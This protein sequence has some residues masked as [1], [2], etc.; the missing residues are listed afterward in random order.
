M[1]MSGREGENKTE[2]I[3]TERQGKV[4]LMTSG[5]TGAPKLVKHTLNALLGRILPSAS[6]AS[7]RE[8]RWL[9]T[10]QPTSFAGMQ[11]ILTAC[12]TG[13]MIVQPL[14]RTA[15]AFYEAAKVHRVTHISGTPTFWRSF[16]L[17]GRPALLSELRQITIGGEAIDQTI[18]NRL[19]TAFPQARLSHIYASTE[20]GALFAVHDRRHGFPAQWLEEGIQGVKLRIREDQLEVLSPHRMVGYAGQRGL[21]TTPDGWLMTGD[22]VRVE[23]DRIVFMG[24]NDAMINVGGTKIFPHEI[25]A[26]LLAMPEIAEAR[27]IG[28]PNP[29]S[30]QIPVA[31]IVVVAGAEGEKVRQAVMKR[32]RESL[33]PERAPRVIRLVSS[34]PVHLS[35]KKG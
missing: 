25:E 17:V 3:E 31:E 18:L 24:R 21:P 6:L 20:A 8:G 30:G 29:I 34:I 35:G 19:S 26:I 32:C 15:A 33:A 9:M 16:L 1:A 4:V 5:T 2:E 14:E 11:V 22:R 23:G 28:V 12:L 13:G 7:N 10:Y 27:V